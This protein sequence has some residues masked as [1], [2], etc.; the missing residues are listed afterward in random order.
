M[1]RKLPHPT[2][3]WYYL[4]LI[5]QLCAQFCKL[6]DYCDKLYMKYQRSKAEEI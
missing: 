1:V 4:V 6:L 3:Q 5:K 2:K